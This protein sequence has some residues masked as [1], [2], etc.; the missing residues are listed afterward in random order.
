MALPMKILS[1][2]SRLHPGQ[3][4]VDRPAQTHYE[5]FP[6]AS[7]LLPGKLRKPVR[8]IYAFARCADDI[9]DEGICDRRQRLDA[10]ALMRHNTEQAA[11]HRPISADEQPWLWPAVESLIH[12]HHAPVAYLLD[13][14]SAFEQD[15][16]GK[17]Y[18]NENAIADYTRRSADP[19][20]RLILHL[21]GYHHQPWL[22]ASDQVCSALQLIN[23]YQDIGAD[24]CTRQRLYLPHDILHRHDISIACA[25]DNPIKQ[26]QIDWG[27]L[28][29][30]LHEL[31]VKAMHS[32]ESG[33]AVLRK[34][35]G[36]LGLELNM[37]CLGGLGLGAKLLK[38]RDATQA[39][40]LTR[41]DWVK[42]L[43]RASRPW[44]V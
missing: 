3:D 18:A 20:G 14:I 40:R 12:E 17:F 2:L 19:V 4:L 6:V 29:P 27:R 9:A 16:G 7:V 37:I 1:R 44:T 33:R 30:V 23:F 38:R 32:L 34:T 13:L 35:G 8:I 26:S 25:D 15:V 36:R 43:W 28:N 5:N 41:S 31:T 11:H 39:P 24:L 10:L 22:A 21:C 42:L